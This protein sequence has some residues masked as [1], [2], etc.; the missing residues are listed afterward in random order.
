MRRPVPDLELT[1]KDRIQ[2]YLFDFNR[3][4]EAFEAP[5]EVTQEA[6]ANAVG[7][8]VT[9]VP[10][11]I[12]PLIAEG[13]VEER[14]A[15]IQRQKRRRKAY[16]LSA[17]GRTQLSALRDALLRSGTA[18]KRSASRASITRIA[19]ESAFLSS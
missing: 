5:V 3:Y 15:H 12:R 8:R 7:I 19:A 18:S 9:H 11:Y 4:A 6:I 10:Q 17:K 2:L 1:V 13:L 16:F 14:T